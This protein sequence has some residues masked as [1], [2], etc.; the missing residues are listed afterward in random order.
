MPGG[1]VA[2]MI[3]PAVVVTADATVG[4]AGA[5]LEDL[6]T[7]VHVVLSRTRWDGT[8]WY[9]LDVGR[10]RRL[11]ADAPPD[12]PVRSVLSWEAIDV[13]P[14][15]GPAEARF[16]ATGVV[17]DGD[18]L[19]GVAVQVAGDRSPASG[20]APG[21]T[22]PEPA[23][24][25]PPPDTAPQG[26]PSL[27]ARLRRRLGT[28]RRQRA[29]PSVP[30]YTTSVEPQ[31][32][33]TTGR[34][35]DG[36]D[37]AAVSAY[38]RL[39]CPSTVGP[40]QRFDL[41]IGLGASE[42]PGTAGA[43]MRFGDV[44]DRFDL[45]V[46]VTA[47]GFDFPDGIRHSLTVDRGH[48]EAARVL[49]PM[50]ACPLPTGAYA[51]RRSVQVEYAYGGMPVGRGWRDVLVAQDTGLRI[52]PAELRDG[53]VPVVPQPGT[54][55]D[56]TVT[57]TEGRETGTLLW[58]F[59]TPHDVELPNHQV[60]RRLD[61][62]SAQVFAVQHVKDIAR[63]DGT[64]T[65][66]N[67]ITGIARTIADV[68]PVEFWSTLEQVWRSVAVPGRVPSLLVVSSD[69]YIP[70]ELASTESEYVDPVLTDP[71]RPALLG[72]Q[73]RLG[74]WLPAGPSSPRGT[75]R[76]AVPPPVDVRVS[77]MAVV[78]G[79][80]AA[81]SG[82]RPLPWASDEGRLLCE[83]Y[84]SLRLQATESEIMTLLDDQL[85]EAGTPV[86]VQAVHVAC[87]GEVD[88]GNP[89]YNGIVLSD[90]ALRLD[91]VTVKGSR[92]GRG[93]Q[94][95]VFLN[96][97]QLGTVG[98]EVLGDYGGMAGA[99]LSE[100][101]RGFV[102]PLWSVDDTVAHDVALEFYR[103]TVDEGATVGEAMRTIRGRFSPTDPSPPS[104]PLA[105]VFYGH[106]DLC[107]RLDGDDR[108]PHQR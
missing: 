28:R 10:L 66:R 56:L 59:T 89:S 57:V 64:L 73:V 102:A 36:G 97:C 75:R 37:G 7:Q 47:Q 3:R 35:D 104:T 58:N 23:A 34:S 76:P 33:G 100:G 92:L 60:E 18:R 65:V 16:G 99:F 74:R 53:A 54:V 39:G 25:R 43:L 52:P 94:P 62:M 87:H 61:A 1:D 11:L 4:E 38:P 48:V 108:P 95:F 68:M 71:A 86:Q 46:Q 51:E 17:L 107:L 98:S 80:Y 14:P 5:A 30:S 96:A 82:F 84:P 42:Q 15:I 9:L 85:Q 31:R 70:W 26:S 103:L 32:P 91:P 72:A 6:P 88:P 67:H 45:D 22:P 93:S 50:V 20:S 24:S 21:R 19:L 69:P 101:A 27:S 83:R 41:E 55:V 63:V 78:I 2:S 105:Y 12:A 90:T 13:L 77:R 40:G 29:G 49:V 106:P 79:D 81:S 44:P 8:R